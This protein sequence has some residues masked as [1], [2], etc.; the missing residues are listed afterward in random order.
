M[1]FKHLA[2]L[3]E[4][5]YISPLEAKSHGSPD[6]T[7]KKPISCTSLAPIGQLTAPG[8]A[9][10]GSHR[11]LHVLPRWKQRKTKVQYAHPNPAFG[12]KMNPVPHTQGVG[13][14]VEEKAEVRGKIPGPSVEEA[15]VFLRLGFC[16][17]HFQS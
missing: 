13:M 4:S 16:I 1:I 2:F 17:W 7:H 6:H 9:A 11:G 15:L 10:P 14:R 3:S 5:Q 8:G 12:M